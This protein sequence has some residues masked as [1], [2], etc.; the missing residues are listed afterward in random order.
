VG[1]TEDALGNAATV[2]SRRSRAHH[3]GRGLQIGLGALVWIAAAGAGVLAFKPLTETPGRT[4][5]AL[6]AAPAVV[7]PWLR[8]VPQEKRD[9]A[10]AASLVQ[11]GDNLYLAGDRALARSKYLEAF[12]AEPTAAL[13]LKLG[14]LARL[15]GAEGEAEARGFFA[16]A[17]KESPASPARSAIREWYP[18]VE[19]PLSTR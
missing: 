3:G 19:Q 10:K 4:A 9:P 11:D 18:E 16:R 8:E 2:A 7:A 13:A 5:S 12:E 1:S 6:P 17:L 14:M 15:R